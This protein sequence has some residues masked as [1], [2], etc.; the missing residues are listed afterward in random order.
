MTE[1]ERNQLR[2]YV[3]RYRLQVY[4][5]R[6]AEEDRLIGEEW[7][8]SEYDHIPHGTMYGYV[9]LKCRCQRCRAARRDYARARRAK[10]LVG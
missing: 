5:R 10:G 2:N 7:Q 4:D 8:D 1:R 6:R 9:R 3:A